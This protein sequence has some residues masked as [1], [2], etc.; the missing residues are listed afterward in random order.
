MR[1]PW[2]RVPYRHLIGPTFFP[3]YLLVLKLALAVTVVVTAGF[4][5]LGPT[6]D[7]ESRPR[8]VEVLSFLIRRG[9]VAFGST[10]LAFAALDLWQSRFLRQTNWDPRRLPA[11]VRLEDRVSRLDSL[12]QLVLVSGSCT[13]RERAVRTCGPVQ[14]PDVR[15][16]PAHY[17]CHSSR[18]ACIVSQICAWQRATASTRSAVALLVRVA[19]KSRDVRPTT[20]RHLR[21]LPAPRGARPQ[22]CLVEVVILREAL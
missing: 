17:A 3:V 22:V 7:A 4:A 9:L 12:I 14:R 13:R 1:F 18:F 11:V 19:A 20:H 16:R 6:G 2:P 21:L 15:S 10:T 8:L 5:V